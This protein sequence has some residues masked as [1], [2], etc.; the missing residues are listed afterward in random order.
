VIPYT[1]SRVGTPYTASDSLLR[2]Q[3]LTT[4]ILTAMAAQQI[5]IAET[6]RAMK[7]ALKRRPDGMS[8]VVSKM[9]TRTLTSI[10]QTPKTTTPLPHTPT[11][12]TSSNAAPTLPEKA[13]SIPLAESRTA[14]RSTTPATH[15]QPSQRTLSSSTR[16]ANPSRPLPP[17]TIKSDTSSPSK[18]MPLARSSWRGSYARSR[19]LTNWS[20]IQV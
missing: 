20:I 12:A 14:N 1:N 15:A 11:A 19:R 4:A 13:A 3:K 5:Q 16:T 18:T 9:H 2:R 8:F 7:L 10:P 17:T 6:I